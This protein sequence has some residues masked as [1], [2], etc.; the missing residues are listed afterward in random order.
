MS[1][2]DTTG[3]APSSHGTGDGQP[4]GGSG[5]NDQNK[6]NPKPAT[7]NKPSSDNQAS[8]SGTKESDV[9]TDDNPDDNVE[10]AVTSGSRPSV[11]SSVILK[12]DGSNYTI[13]RTIIPSVLGGSPFALEVAKG[14]L[15]A[16][17]KEMR[18]TPA[19]KVTYKHF[20]IGN[21]AAKYI[22][23]NSID[24]MLA[25]SL[26]SSR[27]DTV[28]AASIYQEII[29]KFDNTNGGLKDIMVAKFMRFKYQES[30][31]AEENL[32]RFVQICSRAAALGM[33]IPED[34]QVTR[35]LDSLPTNW[36]PFR[37][38]WS[39]R[40]PVDKTLALLKVAIESEALR[41]GKVDAAEITALFSRM[42]TPGR[43]S[44]RR[45]GNYRRRFDSRRTET[46]T[47]EIICYN[48]NRK[49]HKKNECRA[50]RRQHNNHRG[51]RGQQPGRR[52]NAN[53][54]EALIVEL[55]D[56]EANA[57]CLDEDFILDSGC[58]HHMLSSLKWMTAYQPY[59]KKRAV[60]L[61]DSRTL[62]AQG[63]GSAKLTV[64]KDGQPST[65]T[66]TEV[67]YVPRLRRNL[68]SMGKLADD[69]FDFDVKPE[70]ITIIQG[71][72]RVCAGRT[73][74]LFVF[75]A[76]DMAETNVASATKAVS[77]SQV[78]RTFAHVNVDTLRKML[79]R[80]GYKVT[81]DFR[82]CE[83][84]VK[85][86]QHRASNRQKPTSAVATR[87]GEIH[88]DL[89]SV[90]TESF[91]RHNYFLTVTDEM[92]RYRK[93]YFLYSKDETPDYL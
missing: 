29:D 53:L 39:A 83:D 12:A 64:V 72:N 7:D 63:F 25:V 74:G 22:L 67:L 13:W 3:G 40:K 27:A 66:L 43:P 73:N 52:P 54:A 60:K 93:I 59:G 45:R 57:T 62:R 32:F 84:C 75:S 23:L 5:N 33:T 58:S 71:S 20:V 90:N 46:N 69:G 38:G 51:R 65:I 31:G 26:F 21:R 48:C 11:V 89:C 41:R 9:K 1:E 70:A 88:C 49:G 18:N 15:S 79:R 19:G 81:E 2:Q 92:S 77:L 4:A 17:P 91:G 24:P 47:S 78:H 50:P 87:L 28:D 61:G 80:E 8:G 36:E 68:I 16:P 82:Q 10:E 86:K 14:E 6:D 42:R 34:L 44:Y 30:L 37:G 35:L 55:S 56:A 85:G 76:T